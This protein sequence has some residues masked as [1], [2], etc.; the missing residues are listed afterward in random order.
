MP[1]PDHSSHLIRLMFMF[2]FMQKNRRTAMLFIRKIFKDLI[3]QTIVSYQKI[4]SP[5]FATGK[6]RFTPSCSQYAIKAIETFGLFKGGILSIKRIFRCHC[7]FGSLEKSIGK[8]W[9]YDPVPSKKP[10]I[11]QSN[12]D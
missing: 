1:T 10:K 4:I 11:K 8:T 6:C 3:I 12:G 9:G 5:Y 2:L 7:S